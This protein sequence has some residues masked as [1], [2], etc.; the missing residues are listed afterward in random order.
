[1][2]KLISLS[3]VA[4]FFL[5][6]V[7]AYAMEVSADSIQTTQEYSGNAKIVFKSSEKFGISSDEILKI[8]GGAVFSG[9]V[10]VS[11]QGSTLKTD[12]AT[13]RK[14]ENGTTLL[15]AKKFSLTHRDVKSS[16][17]P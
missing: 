12:S 1:M 11:F 16:N 5:S 15:E 10:I 6:T 13:V 8:N 3:V 9:N 4:A 14:Q 17:S 7:T 2:K